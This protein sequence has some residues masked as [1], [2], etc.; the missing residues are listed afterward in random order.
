[1]PSLKYSLPGDQRF[2]TL[3]SIVALLQKHG[4][5][6]LEELS[7]R[8]DVKPKTM[9][10][11]LSTLNTASFMPRNAE[12]QLPYFI[13]LDRVDEEG[14]VCLELDEGPQGVPRITR[15]QAVA[16]LAGLA[17]LRSLPAVSDPAEI[18]ELIDLLANEQSQALEISLEPKVADADLAVLINAIKNDH[19]IKCQ[20]VNS[21]GESSLREIDPIVVV[22][23]ENQWFLRGFC[24]RNQEIRT[25]R[26]DRMVEATE[27]P[28][29]RGKEA[30][31]ADSTPEE[32]SAIYAPAPGDYEVVLD[33]QPEARQLASMAVDVTEIG[34]ADESILRVKLNLGYLPD[35]GPLVTR[36]GSHVRVVSP[37]EAQ[38]VVRD[39]AKK[40]L[41]ANLSLSNLD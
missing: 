4:E 41:E 27:L 24:L 35:L 16:L 36:F 10:G 9:R 15:P 25:F 23:Q 5:L 26:L 22:S 1:M 28:D 19:R 38:K 37:I 12:E 6:S 39:F 18:D 20:Y 21:K 8:F 29:E 32:V 34:E 11:M 3:M 13:D 40:T 30:K 33:L 31:T 7:N 14:V 17:Y 2:N